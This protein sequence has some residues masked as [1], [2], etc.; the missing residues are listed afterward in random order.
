MSGEIVGIPY[1]RRPVCDLVGIDGNAFSI[2]GT[3][4]GAL[5]RA[6]LR[7]EARRYIE[8]ATSG[9]YDHLLCVSMSYVRS[10]TLDGDDDAV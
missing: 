4:K 1:D 7:D 8:E 10:P 5:E 3:V 2:M 9:D 6:G